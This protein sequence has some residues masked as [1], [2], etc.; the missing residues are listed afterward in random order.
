MDYKSHKG[1]IINIDYV[2]DSLGDSVATYTIKAALTQH[3]VYKNISQS[4][5]TKKISP[6]DVNSP[7]YKVGQLVKWNLI[8]KGSQPIRAVLEQS[9]TIREVVNLYEP[10]EYKVRIKIDDWKYIN[11]IITEQKLIQNKNLY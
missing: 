3:K 7:K 9:G 1:Q 11:R 2:Q 5:I 10:F 8:V 6:P 4:R